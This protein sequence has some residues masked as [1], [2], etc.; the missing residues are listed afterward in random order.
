MKIRT[1]AILFSTVA[2]A[3][4]LAIMASPASADSHSG[5]HVETPHVE[6]PHVETPHVETPHVETKHAEKPEVKKPEVKKG[7]KGR[8]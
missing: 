8:R 4:S 2:A 3:S 6:T 5:T 1:R 7:R